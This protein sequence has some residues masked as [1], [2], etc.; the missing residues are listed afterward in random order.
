MALILVATLGGGAASAAHPASQPSRSTAISSAGP[1]SPDGYVDRLIKTARHSLNYGGA[2]IQHQPYGV[3]I[4][5]VAYP[6]PPVQALL[7]HVPPGVTAAWH[8]CAYTF[9]DLEHETR[10]LI[11]KFH[12][13]NVIGPN[14]SGS[15][16]VVGTLN[17]PLLSSYHPGQILGSTFG[18]R[19][20]REGRIHGGTLAAGTL[21]RP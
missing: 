15:G 16:L 13:I 9:S 17:K 2:V 7:D 14:A 3:I 18:L 11:A 19:V 20:V 8:R 6:T 10:R 5:G 1:A 12:Y 4:Y 21:T